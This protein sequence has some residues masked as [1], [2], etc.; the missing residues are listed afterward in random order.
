MT[1]PLPPSAGD[2]PPPLCRRCGRP[3]VLNATKYE[4]FERMHYVCFHFEFEH[5]PVD[6]DEEC[7]AG[8]CPSRAVNPRSDRRPV[9]E[10][11]I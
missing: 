4:T 2:A 3:V 9:P 5:D 1:S 6:V 10:R 11:P 8:G 7:G